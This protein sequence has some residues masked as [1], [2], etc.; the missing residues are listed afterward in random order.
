MA[1]APLPVNVHL[2][3]AASSVKPVVVHWIPATKE[4]YHSTGRAL[5]SE[6]SV[7]SI[8][9]VVCDKKKISVALDRKF[10]LNFE[11]KNCIHND[12]KTNYG[13]VRS[14]CSSCRV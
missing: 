9:M 2:V 6:W 3:T 1:L 12:Y 14:E 13:S 11:I 5:P 8:M 4:V 10:S 7:N